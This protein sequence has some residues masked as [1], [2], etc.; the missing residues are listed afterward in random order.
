MP[1]M[2]HPPT[3]EVN[4]AAVAAD[5]PSGKD[6]RYRLLGMTPAQALA[7]AGEDRV[8]SVPMKMRL[9]GA[10]SMRARTLGLSRAA[11]LRHLVAADA[12]AAGI[13]LD[14]DA[15][16]PPRQRRRQR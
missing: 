15:T 7:E 12:R 13:D 16:A 2:P 3:D 4:R 5:H 10:C 9:A 11:Y 14:S 6:W 1:Q 8:I